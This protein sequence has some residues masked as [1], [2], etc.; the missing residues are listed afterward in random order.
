MTIEQI[1]CDI[2]LITREKGFSYTLFLLLRHHLFHTPEETATMDW[3]SRLSIQ[4]LTLLVGLWIKSKA[5]LTIPDEKTALSQ[6]K[7]IQDLF[8]KLHSGHTSSFKSSITKPETGSSTSSEDKSH[9]DQ[10]DRDPKTSLSSAMATEPIFYSDSGAYDFQYLEIIEEKYKKDEDWL[11]KNRNFN[12]RNFKKIAFELKNL[13]QEKIN[14]I[15]EVKNFKQLCKCIFDGFSFTV[16][17]LANRTNL[18][19]SDIRVFLDNFS[20]EPGT[21]NQDLKHPGQYNKIFS[22]PIVHI[23][24][25]K[26]SVP[27]AFNLAQSLYESPFYWMSARESGDKIQ[28]DKAS[29]HRGNFNEEFVAR[30]L[31]NIFGKENVYKGLKIKKSKGET[32]SD[33]DILAIAGNKAII[34][35]AKSKKLT[36]LAKTG[37]I[38][39]LEID[40]KG[41]VQDA[42]EQGLICRE[43][44]LDP[45]STFID[46]NGNTV[47]ISEEINECYLICVTSDNYPGIIHQSNFFLKRKPENPYPIALNLFDL[48]IICHYLT[49]PFRFLYYIN[50]RIKLMDQCK[51][52]NEMAYL[53][54]HLKH[55]LFRSNKHDCIFIPPSYGQLIDANYPAEKGYQPKASGDLK[56]EWANEQFNEIEEK[57]KSTGEP[58][59]TDILFSL[60][61]LEGPGADELIEAIKKTKA[62]VK[63]TGKAQSFS[64]VVGENSF[65]ITCAV[66]NADFTKLETF[67]LNTSVARKYKAKA[68]LWLG[69]GCIATSPQIIDTL[70][71][72]NSDWTY[73][74]DEEELANNLGKPTIRTKDGKKLGR[75][76]KCVC[77]SG[78]KFKRCCGI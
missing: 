71:F 4:E 72:T 2:E 52:D 46:E 57:L 26:Y 31:E 61:D 78:K 9:D 35:Q 70:I 19:E 44:I 16:Q 74:A 62:K 18:E 43:A 11:A 48:E 36:E 6:A 28:E 23:S 54:W 41:A 59:L 5:D 56:S 69:I 13:V 10:S 22:H 25:G 8:E 37:N 20:V 49:D 50:Q 42:Y 39:Q 27:I 14:K 55:K 53:A 67:L 65:G 40:F 24:E 75:N 68:K 21:A 34:V 17:E 63:A 77:G 76:A 47:Q 3:H 7:R 32:T 30:Q 66:E 12:A 51:A 45:V 64:I 38:E 33:I 1:I 58:G 29:I 73:N 15:K 60:F